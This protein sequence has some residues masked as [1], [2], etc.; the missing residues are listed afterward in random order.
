MSLSARLICVEGRIRTRVTVRND[1]ARR[2]VNLR[3]KAERSRV[4]TILIGA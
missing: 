1:L 3:R 4:F 2:Q